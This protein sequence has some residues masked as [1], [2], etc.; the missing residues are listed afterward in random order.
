MHAWNPDEQ[1]EPEGW[2][3]NPPTGR[4][5]PNGNASQEYISM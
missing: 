1:K 3:R 4:R 2:M 5:R